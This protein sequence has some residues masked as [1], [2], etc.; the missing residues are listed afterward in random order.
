MPFN[1]Y[2]HELENLEKKKQII[3]AILIIILVALNTV[4]S[5]VHTEYNF[6]LIFILLVHIYMIFYTYPRKTINIR[7]YI[8][9]FTIFTLSYMV[10]FYRTESVYLFFIGIEFALGALYNMTRNKFILLS[11]FIILA[12]SILN[13]MDMAIFRDKE[14]RLICTLV[15]TSYWMIAAA[16]IITKFSFLQLNSNLTARY[17]KDWNDCKQRN[18][19]EQSDLVD[20]KK[21]EELSDLA[22]KSHS[23]FILKFKEYFPN[24]TAK[25]EQANPSIV[26]TEFEVIA[27]LKLNFSTKEIARAT[28]STVRSIESKKYRIR[29]KL[30]IPSDIDMS[31][32]L[33]QI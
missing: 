28:D 30:Q 33:S 20:S 2:I 22:Y 9:G 12:L 17:K 25:I 14:N 27:M 32:Y 10:S 8:A 31:M 11:I 15:N 13:Y 1:R 3:Y 29:K 16:A 4:K 18:L 23:N 19:S 6:I 21:L 5:C 7:L 26:T 24:F